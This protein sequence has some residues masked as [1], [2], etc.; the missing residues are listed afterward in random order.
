[1]SEEKRLMIQSVV[2][3]ASGIL[4]GAVLGRDGHFQP[5]HV[6]SALILAREGLEGFATQDADFDFSGEMEGGEI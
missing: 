4:A 5:G 1:M 2:T 6:C 3:L